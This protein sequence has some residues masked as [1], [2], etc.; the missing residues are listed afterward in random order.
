M[1]DWSRLA[2][3]FLQTLREIIGTS[4]E[5]IPEVAKAA[6]SCCRAGLLEDNSYKLAF[7]LSKSAVATPKEEPN[8]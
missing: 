3:I 4:S 6:N 1:H 7:V 5:S 8:W 2:R